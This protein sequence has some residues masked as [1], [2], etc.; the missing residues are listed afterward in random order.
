MWPTREASQGQ[1][2]GKRKENAETSCG[3]PP[4]THLASS[5]R[6]GLR[7][8]FRRWWSCARCVFSLGDNG[9]WIAWPACPRRRRGGRPLRSAGA[10]LCGCARRWLLRRTTRPCSF[11]PRAPVRRPRRPRVAS[12]GGQWR[13]LGIHVGGGVGGAASHRGLRTPT[14]CAASLPLGVC[15]RCVHPLRGV[16]CRLGGNR[17]GGGGA[18]VSSR[19][20]DPGAA[21]AVAPSTLLVICTLVSSQGRDGGVGVVG[22]YVAV[23]HLAQCVKRVQARRND[24]AHCRWSGCVGREA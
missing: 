21:S 14:V 22:P 11:A 4:T 10:R 1:K 23:D 16:W 13:R 17:C 12:L 20:L 6:G 8:R 18:T 3:F 15:R 19:R 9:L 2:E 7:P 24:D 5:R